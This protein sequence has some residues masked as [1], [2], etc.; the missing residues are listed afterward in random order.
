MEI[1]GT[2]GKIYCTANKHH[3][4]A[5]E[6]INLRAETYERF[7]QINVIGQKKPAYKSIGF[8]C[9]GVI[10]FEYNQ[11]Y[12]SGKIEDK[13]QNYFEIEIDDELSGE[14]YILRNVIFD[15]I[16]LLSLLQKNIEFTFDDYEIV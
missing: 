8:D 13:I 16:N 10:T 14:R 15:T 3:V 4:I 5:G 6:L 7:V 9:S 12:L 11:S 1:F 2:N